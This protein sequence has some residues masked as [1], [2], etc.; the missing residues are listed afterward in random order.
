MAVGAVVLAVL[1][2]QRRAVGHGLAVGREVEER[3]RVA[4]VDH[5][6]AVHLA[7]ADVDLRH[8]GISVAYASARVVHRAYGSFVP[9]PECFGPIGERERLAESDY[10]VGDVGA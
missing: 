1:A 6:R 2:V 4:G 7:Q 10:A 9:E 3:V 8:V 5:M